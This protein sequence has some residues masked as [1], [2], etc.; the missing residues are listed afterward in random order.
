M[1]TAD[2][3]WGGD[4]PG[5]GEQSYANIYQGGYRQRSARARAL[6]W[7]QAGLNTGLHWPESQPFYY[8]EEQKL[9]SPDCQKIIIFN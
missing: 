4:V 2:V 3:H 6:R 7:A 9:L 5:K 1:G 8:Y